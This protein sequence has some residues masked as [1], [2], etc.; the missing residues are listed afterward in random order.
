M[1]TNADN[2]ILC[3]TG[4]GT[5][6][7][8]LYRRFWLPALLPSELPEADCPPVRLRFLSEDLVA[9]R[10]TSG[11]VAFMQNAC[12]HRGAS[13]FFGRNE[14]DG[15]RCVYHGWKF[16]VTGDCVDMPNEP[17]ESNFKHKIK[18]TVYPGAD[19]GGLVWIYM[20]PRDKQPELPQYDWC[21]RTD[22]NRHYHKWLQDSNWAQGVEGNL[23]SS[24]AS[25]LHRFF[26]REHPWHFGGADRSQGGRPLLADDGAPVLTARET[27]F[28]FV[29]G[30]ARKT[31]DQRVYWRV[32]P[33][34]M[35]NYT[36]IPSPSGRFNGFFTLPMDDEH[37]WWFVIEEQP[38]KIG[39]EYP[40]YVEIQ[41]DWRQI[42]NAGN[43]YLIDRTA[44]RT[45]NYSG[46]TT[47]RVQDAAM[48]ES[49]GAIMDRTNE[50]LATSDMA[51]IYMRRLMIK[52]ARDLERG[53]EPPLLSHPEWHNML[54]IDAV[55]VER[56]LALFWEQQQ[57]AKA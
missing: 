13:M 36:V 25:F 46:M 22:P 9:F 54:P 29:Y 5:P 16:D 10:D 23:D 27:E 45:V 26:D 19:W 31:A 55:S 43:D 11:Q 6:M 52:A 34:I 20:G 49:M 21:L 39:P 4:P 24:H 48:M 57:A 51:I 2:S 37:S 7:G 33:F 40:G 12:P 14:E 42:R 38:R 47:N 56:N 41:S 35:P 32:T 1:L 17:A 30:A 15:L 50:H 28:G 3:Q 44:Q 8:N 53:F 18:A